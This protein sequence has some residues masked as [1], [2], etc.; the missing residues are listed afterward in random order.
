MQPDECHSESDVA[1]FF[2]RWLVWTEEQTEC[3]EDWTLRASFRRGFLL[4][5]LYENLKSGLWAFHVDED[6]WDERTEPLL[7]YHESL[8]KLIDHVSVVYCKR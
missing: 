5:Q 6:S 3:V 1:R 2:L 8:G 7:G 4:H